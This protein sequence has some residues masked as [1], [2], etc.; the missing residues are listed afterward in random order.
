VKKAPE[1]GGWTRRAIAGILAAPAAAA[2][3]SPVQAVE[4]PRLAAPDAAIRDEMRKTAQSLEAV[5]IPPGIEPALEF[6]P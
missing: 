1:P 6:K 5:V 4:A 2:V 3:T